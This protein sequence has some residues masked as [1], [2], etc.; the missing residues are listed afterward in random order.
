MKKM[1]RTFVPIVLV[2][3][4]S[5]SGCSTKIG[6]QPREPKLGALLY[7]DYL[8]ANDVEYAH[9]IALEL[10]TNPKFFNSPLGGRNAGSDAEHAAAAYLAAEMKKIGLKE[11]SLD[12]FPVDTWQFNGAE[13]TILEAEGEKRVLLPY[14]YASGGTSP[15]GIT[16]ELLYVG[17]GTM[18]DYEEID[19]RGK[20]V[21]IDL[22]QREN[23]WVTYPTLEAQFRGA[24]AIINSNVGGFAEL[25]GDTMNCQDMCGPVGIPSVNLSVNDADY[26][27]GLLELGTVTL[28]LKVDNSVTEGG[29]SYNV[30]GKIPGRNPEE[31]IIV[32]D[33]YDVHFWG[34][35]DNNCAVG[36]TLAIAKGLIDAGYQPERTLVFVLHGSEEWGAID[37]PYDWSIGAWNQVNTVHPDWVGQALAYINFELP[38]YEFAESVRTDTTPELYTLLQEFVA[39]GAPEPEGCYPEGIISDGYAQFTYSD[40]FS[41]TAAGIP[42][43]VNGFLLTP[44][45]EDVF[46]FYYTTYHSQFDIPETYNQAVL[47]FNLDFYGSLAMAI[48]QTPAL[49]MDFRNQYTRIGEAVDQ[50]LC[51]EAGADW[52]S[53][54][55]A[56]TALGEAADGAYA[57]VDDLNCRYSD[58][59]GQGAE[60]SEYEPFRQRGRELN[61]VLLKTFKKM[62]DSFL[63]LSLETPI[64]GPE[65]YQE[66]ITLLRESI[67]ELE[68]GNVDYVVDELLWQVNG[69][70]EWYNY[71]FSPE[72]IEHMKSQTAGDNLFWGTGKLLSGV[73]LYDVTQSLMAAYG[74]GGLSFGKEIAVMEAEIRNQQELLKNHLSKMTKDLREITELLKGVE[75]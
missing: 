75:G 31:S 50:T 71:Y 48:D 38:A 44:D 55:E 14:S 58:L 16:A 46:D 56:L 2:V 63:L 57:V 66:N 34:F 1:H 37:T 39:D 67:D 4:I 5:L 70:E 23:W 69:V 7:E 62:Q 68:Q 22:D 54:E 9:Q 74:V 24:V 3:L 36:L 28:N 42:S 27:K 35:Q 15:E 49:K 53:F 11:V 32:G 72:T 6:M 47:Q 20:V 30:V 12:E 59:V 73:E 52:D 10:S 19:V 17:D 43:M 25:N 33:H 65:Y 51:R 41:Y 40:D 8:T 64:V 18:Y 13:L 29:V 21:L 45:G 61:G 60:P 26:L